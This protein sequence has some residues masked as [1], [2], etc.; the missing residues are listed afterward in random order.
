MM[1]GSEIRITEFPQTPR[2]KKFLIPGYVLD[3]KQ[4]RRSLQK[5][6]INSIPHFSLKSYAILFYTPILTD[7]TI[8]GDDPG[9]R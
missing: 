9:D 7:A 1:T 3:V 5:E 4:R 6:K 8:S 2:L